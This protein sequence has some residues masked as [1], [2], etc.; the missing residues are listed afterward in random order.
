MK[1]RVGQEPGESLINVPPTFRL[2]Y[3]IAVCT[4]VNKKT[5]RGE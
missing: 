2:L 1:W 4:R 5:F 3:F